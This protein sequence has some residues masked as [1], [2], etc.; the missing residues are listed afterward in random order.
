MLQPALAAPGQVEQLRELTVTAIPVEVEWTR[1]DI[2]EAD[3]ASVT[4]DWSTLPLDPRAL[5]DCRL[6]VYC[7]DV[8]SEERVLSIGDR[9]AV[10][11]VGFV[12]EVETDFGDGGERV[13]LRARD[14]T[15]RLIDT[16][17]PIKGVSA[18]GGKVDASKIAQ[19]S[20]RADRPLSQI[21]REV[22]SHLPPY[23]GTS[24]RVEDDRSVASVTG[25][26]LWTPPAGVTCWDAIVGVSKELGQTPRWELGELVV[27]P[28][29]PVRAPDARIVVYG[30]QVSR[31]ALRRSL[32]PVA[33]KRIVFRAVDAATR[34]VVEGVWPPPDD[35]RGDVAYTLPA[36]DWSSETLRDRARQVFTT[37]ERRQVSGSFETIAMSDLDDADLVGLQSGDAVYLRARSLDR[38]RVLGRS[39]GE[40]A[41]YLRD[42]GMPA[43]TA[44]ALAQAWSSS[45]D[46]ATLF[47]VVRARH[48]WSR[49][50]GY[51]LTADFG[52]AIGV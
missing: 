7:A 40:L 49:Q 21:I 1:N 6:V 22:L 17:L 30:D 20:L 8:R 46:L 15:G 33:T 4:L 16:K 45:E 34:R 38:T 23:Q 36:G 42:N 52:N 19:G 50:D 13:L 2:N 47:Y 37:W 12:D 9:A 29:Q 5:R 18:R 51:R 14:Y 32:N 41:A 48:R 28:P 27:G 39:R 31:M 26:K 43:T 3:E 10:R 11:F 24:L 44:N 25:K 35:D